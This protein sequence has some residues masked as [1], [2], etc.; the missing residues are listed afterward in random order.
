[1]ITVTGAASSLGFKTINALTD[2]GVSP[3]QIIAI[4]HDA[5]VL[6]GSIDDVKALGV[7]VRDADLTQA[8][9][10]TDVFAGT[11]QLMLLPF[12]GEET[13]EPADDATLQRTRNVVAAVKAVPT[14]N[15]VGYLSGLGA[16]GVNADIFAAHK[17]TED[18]IQAAFGSNFTFLR[19]GLQAERY[20]TLR[21][22]GGLDDQKI[23]TVANGGEV[24]AVGQFDIAAAAAEVILGDGHAAQ[25]LDIVGE[26]PFSVGA[27]AA[28]LTSISGKTI[29][30]VEQS[31][32]DYRQLLTNIGTVDVEGT[33]AVELA[34][35]ANRLRSDSKDLRQLIG[36]TPLTVPQ[37]LADFFSQV[38]GA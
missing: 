33:L 32:D 29:A 3:S 9:G 5:N 7:Q 28:A 16:D 2:R 27:F 35:K 25:T 21:F 4:N 10:L 36:R 8:S 34:T 19:S 26:E 12:T 18:L 13:Y 14:A 15:F 6:G 23:F 24:S 1:M 38:A 37:A 31:D 30:V 20:T 22:V 11:S 17:T